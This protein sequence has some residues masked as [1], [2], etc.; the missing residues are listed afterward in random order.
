M[1]KN[2][3]ECLHCSNPVT[4]VP[5][6]DNMGYYMYCLD[7]DPSF[8]VDVVNLEDLRKYVVKLTPE[9]FF[10]KYFE[11]RDTFTCK[12]FVDNELREI[13]DYFFDE[14][15]D[16]TLSPFIKILF[17]E[18][19]VFETTDDLAYVIELHLS[20][21]IIRITDLMLNNTLKELVGFLRNQCIA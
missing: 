14:Q 10:D 13:L 4:G 8:D 5:D 12:M 9:K 18:D 2:T 7:C 15:D 16:L 6:K 20:D 19:Y 1:K 21:K 3:R 11:N 17:D